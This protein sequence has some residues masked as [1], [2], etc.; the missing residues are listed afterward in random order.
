MRYFFKVADHGAEFPD[1]TGE[2]CPTP[3]AARVRAEAL[4]RELGSDPDYR[5]FTII[6]TD[7]QGKEVARVS[8]GVSS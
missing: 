3:D 6:V 2:D 8:I 7:E 5:G 1:D 4:A